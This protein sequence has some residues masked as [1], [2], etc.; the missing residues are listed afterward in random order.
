[1]VVVIKGPTVVAQQ[2]L[3]PDAIDRHGPRFL[4]LSNKFEGLVVWIQQTLGVQSLQI[5]DLEAF[6][7]S[8]THFCLEIMDR[9]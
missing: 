4:P 1:M 6:R 7:A 8:N 5:H 9:C 3:I 2:E